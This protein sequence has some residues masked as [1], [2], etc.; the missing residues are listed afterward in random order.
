MK[1]ARSQVPKS[2]CAS[3]G[4]SLRHVHVVSPASP[5]EPP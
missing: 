4:R 1:Q 2:E 3:E 5:A